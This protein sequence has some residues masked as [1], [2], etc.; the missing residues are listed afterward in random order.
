MCQ[1]TSRFKLTGVRPAS[2]LTI[3]CL[4]L[5]ANAA[6]IVGQRAGV[7]SG[8]IEDPAIVYETAPTA[9]AV[10]ELNRKLEDGRVTFAF[11]PVSGYLRSALDALNVPVESQL[12]VYTHTSQQGLRVDMQN[13]RAVYFNDSVALAFIRGAPTLEVWAQDPKQGTIFYS[14]P[15]ESASPAAPRFKRET[16][17]LECHLSWETLA[18]PG[19]LVLTT[20]PRRDENDFAD[21]F[22]VDH[23][24]DVSRR[25]G[26][27]YVTGTQ[28]PPQ[29][30]GNLPL[31]MPNPTPSSAPAELS[32]AGKVDLHGYLTP[33][34]DV[35]A[36]MVLE[37]QTHAMNLITRANWEARLGKADHVREA[38]ADLVD[39]FLFVDE[40]PIRRRLEG[41]SGFAETFSA[42]GPKD[43]KGRSLR[44]LQLDGRLMKYPLSY[45]IYSPA[46]DALPDATRS[47]VVARLHQILSGEDVHPKYAHLTPPIRQAILKILEDTFRR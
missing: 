12:L 29:H 41:S 14:L 31:F 2:V 36:L 18:V 5:A 47:A 28:L 4:L 6:I 40:A 43:L 15:Q 23:R 11:D 24:D 10:T 42:Q 38:I 9:T 45:M 19:P 35:V 44:E 13:P 3:A 27:W 1:A 20:F 25:W 21:G 16:G 8:S 22:V 17:C 37:H 30:M 46:F 33:Y 32:L 34:S 26:G 39:Y 7:F